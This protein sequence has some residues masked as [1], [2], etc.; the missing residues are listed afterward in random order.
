MEL[1]DIR[2][3]DIRTVI[4]RRRGE[5]G[6]GERRRS[7]DWI[8]EIVFVITRRNETFTRAGA[9]CMF[10]VSDAIIRPL[11]YISCISIFLSYAARVIVEL[12]A[13]R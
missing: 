11:Y 8:D 2:T 4:F 12:I 10:P 13:K 3:S 7:G 9:S 1:S 6:G 5:G